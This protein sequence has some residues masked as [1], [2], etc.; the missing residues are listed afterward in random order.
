MRIRFISRK[1]VYLPGCLPGPGQAGLVLPGSFLV[2]PLL[3]RCQPPLSWMPAV[4][5]RGHIPHSAPVQPGG[6]SVSSF[7]K[8]PS[9]RT[10]SASFL[11]FAFPCVL[12]A[13]VLLFLT[14]N[15]PISATFV[16]FQ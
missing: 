1:A 13:G 14:S 7:C 8:V 3:P 2:I 16:D 15:C 5:L 6:L 11:L 9:S 10:D 12:L 4:L